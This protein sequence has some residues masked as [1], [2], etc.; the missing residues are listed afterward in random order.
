MLSL[1]SEIYFILYTLIL[2]VV[3][4]STRPSHQLK[5]CPVV[6]VYVAFVLLSDEFSICGKQGFEV[7]ENSSFM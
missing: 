7:Q 5:G 4:I 3:H 6:F 2:Y 1:T